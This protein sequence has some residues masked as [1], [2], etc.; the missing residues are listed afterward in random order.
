MLFHRTILVQSCIIIRF[1]GRSRAIAL[2]ILMYT[3]TTYFFLKILL[4]YFL[5]ALGLHCCTWTFSSC[6]QQGLFF[7]ASTGSRAH[8]LQ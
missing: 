1:K 6:G 4:I 8:R 5:A 7:V 2:L 3:G